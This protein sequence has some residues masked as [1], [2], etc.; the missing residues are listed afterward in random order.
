ME[1]STRFTHIYQILV[2]HRNLH[3]PGDLT[4]GARGAFAR[5][6]LAAGGFHRLR[7]SLPVRIRHCPNFCSKEAVP[8]TV[9][10][11]LHHCQCPLKPPH[12]S[13]KVP[14]ASTARCPLEG[15]QGRQQDPW[16]PPLPAP[17]PKPCLPRGLAGGCSSPHGQPQV[18][19]C[20]GAPT[21]NTPFLL[22]RLPR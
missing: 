16:P 7:F 20:H 9:F 12:L 21:V 10:L 18:P 6:S 15:D 2:T 8:P 4:A 14:G 17:W 13:H 5:G 3:P 11:P 1:A 19:L 22:L